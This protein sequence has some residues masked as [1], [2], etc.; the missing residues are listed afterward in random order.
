MRCT[1]T[2]ASGF[3]TGLV[4]FGSLFAV[5]GPLTPPGAPSS[6]MK[7]LDEVEARI[8]ISFTMT[9]SQPGSYYL[10]RNLNATTTG[11]T[12]DAPNVHL[13][14]NGY[15]IIGDGAGLTTDRGI[16][17]TAGGPV[18]ITNGFIKNFL[19]HGVRV[20]SEN[21]KVRLEN[22]HVENCLIGM[23][24]RGGGVV[25]D[26]TS[27][28]NTDAG[29][30][31]LGHVIFENCYAEF[32]GQEGFIAE[33]GIFSNCTA[34][35]NGSHGFGLGTDTINTTSDSSAI[36]NNC[37]ATDN[38]GSG[39]KIDDDAALYECVA[40]SNNQSGFLG[41]ETVSYRGCVAMDNILNGIVGGSGSSVESCSARDNLG[42]GIVVSFGSTVTG[43]SAF[44]ND[45]DG[46]DHAGGGSISNCSTRNNGI[47]GV[48][49]GDACMVTACTSPGNA[50]SG[51]NLGADAR[52]TNCQADGNGEYGIF[53]RDG[54]TVDSNSV[55]QNDIGIFLSVTASRSSIAVRN[56]ITLDHTTDAIL[57]SPFASWAFLELVTSDTNF[58][59]D[60]PWANLLH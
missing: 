27:R 51:F 58:L 34:N 20:S 29:F 1:A 5:A 25:R 33:R 17:I 19:G 8:P 10:T 22:V 59:V 47:D 42:D 13:D 18:S 30:S 60:Q 54:S 24:I 55:S 49:G 46:I 35:D 21:T 6:T 3:A 38:G 40:K 16:D 44:S 7:T 37:L 53:V 41:A 45:G 12:I 43:S 28:S 15:S 57:G 11:I 50:A 31:A 9:I 14:L 32:N 2:F 26:C 52:I 39:F 48:E 36:L 23:F 56:T 4:F